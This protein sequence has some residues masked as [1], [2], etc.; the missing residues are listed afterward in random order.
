MRYVMKRD[1]KPGFLHAEHSLIRRDCRAPADLAI[2][3]LDR[4]LAGAGPKTLSYHILH[5]PPGRC[6]ATGNST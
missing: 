2:G 4:D 6:V 5:A 1:P 3:P